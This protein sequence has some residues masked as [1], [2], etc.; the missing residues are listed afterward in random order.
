MWSQIKQKRCEMKKKSVARTL[1]ASDGVLSFFSHFLLS[2]PPQLFLFHLCYFDEATQSAV[3][4]TES[5][6]RCAS[7]GRVIFAHL[8][9]AR[10]KEDNGQFCHHNMTRA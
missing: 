1:L 5:R 2:H 4:M 9:G 6:T 10:Q 3:T 8:F 7:R